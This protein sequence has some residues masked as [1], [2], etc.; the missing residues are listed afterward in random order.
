MKNVSDRKTVIKAM[1]TGGLALIPFVLLV[2]LTACATPP[3]PPPATGESSVAVQKGVPGGVVVNTVDVSA[4][5]VS[6]DQANRK[7]TLMDE[8]GEKFTVKVGPEAV[9]FDQVKKGDLLKVTLTE[10]LVIFLDKEGTESSDAGAGV[11]AL[12]PKGAKPGGLLAQTVQ[13]VATVVSIDATNRTTTLR[14][15]DGTTKTFPVRDDIDLSKHKAGERVVF[16]VTESVA[17]SVEKE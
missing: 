7:A 13:I 12:A 16:R 1:V 10:E 4:R 6:V 17:I 15:E 3:P 5:V 2:L 8:D 9:N 14:F 11:V